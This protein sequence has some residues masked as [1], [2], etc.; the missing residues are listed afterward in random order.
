MSIWRRVGRCGIECVERECRNRE[1]WGL[2]CHG[3]L[4]GGSSPWKDVVLE[5]WI[6]RWSPT[7]QI[8][9]SHD[10]TLNQL[11]FTLHSSSHILHCFPPPPQ[12][13]LRGIKNTHI[14]S[15]LFYWHMIHLHTKEDITVTSKYGAREPY[16][17]LFG[18][19]G[20]CTSPP[21]QRAKPDRPTDCPGTLQPPPPL[22]LL[23]FS[24]VY[25][26]S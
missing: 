2:S 22:H 17:R 8:L 19:Y 21:Q 12:T 4:P 23:L 10:N 6:D 16:V 24:T 9:V 3:H 20:V 5:K 14:H 11:L 18:L 26:T 15:C 7:S 13:L 1:T 25:M